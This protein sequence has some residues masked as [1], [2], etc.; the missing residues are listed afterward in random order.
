MTIKLKSVLGGGADEVHMVTRETGRRARAATAAILA[1]AA[2]GAVAT[3]DFTGIGIID[4]SCADEFLAKLLTRL[5]AGEY[6]D[7]YL[8][9]AGV[10]PSQKE[11]L[12]VALERKKMA[13][14]LKGG[15]GDWHCLGSLKPYLRETLELVMD[16]SVMSARGLSELLEIE[17]NN[18]ST[19]LINLHRQRLVT[20]R[21]RFIPEGG[22]EFMYAGLKEI[23]PEVPGGGEEG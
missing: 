16:R 5:T 14:I 12:E 6:G 8:R 2:E 18:S 7:K 10:T 9:L 22:R 21:E 23:P 19:R 17:L 1:T 3:L 15:N 13:T 4:F 11:N 20:R